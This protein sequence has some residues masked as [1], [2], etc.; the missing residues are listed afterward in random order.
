LDACV[1]LVFVNSRASAAATSRAATAVVHP[2]VSEFATPGVAALALDRNNAN[3][4]WEVAS[5]SA[6]QCGK[7]DNPI[8]IQVTGGCAL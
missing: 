4:L 5:T 2:S 6:R 1:D 8:K 7:V 3:R